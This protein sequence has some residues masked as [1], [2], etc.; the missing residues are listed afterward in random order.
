MT[1]TV[2]PAA[3]IFSRAVAENFY[4]GAGP[5]NGEDLVQRLGATSE[6]VEIV[7]DGLVA[8]GLLVLHRMPLPQK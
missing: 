5:L 4:R 3:S 1:S 8:Q 7:I 2:P 6:A